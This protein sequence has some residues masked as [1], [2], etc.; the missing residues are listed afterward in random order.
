MINPFY[1][2]SRVGNIYRI[3]INN[4]STQHFKEL[5]KDI[6]TL[7]RTEKIND[8]NLEVYIL[9]E[10]L[11]L[12][13]FE[14]I[15]NTAPNYFYIV[16]KKREYRFK[17]RKDILVKQGFNKNKTE[18]EIMFDRKL[19]RIYGCGNLKYKFVNG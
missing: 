7:K 1:I 15:K 14:F 3:I 18:K 6:A 8:S 9:H 12:S 16:N 17:Y 2:S 19:Y 10:P 4:R 5:L 13:N 11:H